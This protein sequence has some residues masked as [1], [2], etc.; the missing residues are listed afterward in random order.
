MARTYITHNKSYILFILSTVQVAKELCKSVL[1]RAIIQGVL[2]KFT[3]RQ[4]HD[5]N[6]TC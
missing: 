4:T 2:T 1:N 6:V 3:L 5:E